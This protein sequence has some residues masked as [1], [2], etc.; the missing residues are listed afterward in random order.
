[1]KNSQKSSVRPAAGTLQAARR[2][3]SEDDSM[4][5]IWTAIGTAIWTTALTLGL[6]VVLLST[7]CFL[8]GSDDASLEKKANG[9]QEAMPTINGDGVLRGKRPTISWKLNGAAVWGFKLRVGTTDWL[10]RY[11]NSGNQP[12]STTSFA[13]Q[14]DLPEDGSEVIVSLDVALDQGWG[15]WVNADTRA[16]TS[17]G[18]DPPAPPPDDELL[19]FPGARG[20]GAMAS[21]GRGG[22]VYHVTSLDDGSNQGTLRYGI[23]EVA[24][25]GPLTIVFD[26]SGNIKLKR[27]LKI[28]SSNLTIA[29]QTAPDGGITLSGYPTFIE[30]ESRS[31]RIKDIIIRYVRFRTG[32]FNA[33][34]FGLKPAKGRGDL[35]GNGGDGVTILFAENIILD[36]VS[37]SW[38]MDETFDVGQSKLVTLQ[39]SMIYEGLFDSYH[40]NSSK[41]EI[42]KHSRTTLIR[43][44]N[45]PEEL[46]NKTRGYSFVGN[47]LAHSNM[48]MP[49]V[50]GHQHDLTRGTNIEFINN[51][52]YNWGERSGH[53]AT[54]A[55]LNMNYVANYL[56]AGPSTEQGTPSKGVNPRTAFRVEQETKDDLNKFLMYQTGNY[57]DSDLDATHDGTAV[58]WEAFIDFE[59]HEMLTEPHG[60]PTAE[61]R[62]A[63]DAYELVLVGSGASLSRDNDDSRVVSEIRNREGKIIDSQDE[64]GGLSVIDSVRRPSNFDTDNDGIPDD[65]EN[66]HGLDPTLSSDA[67]EIDSNT[68]GYTHLEVYLNSLVP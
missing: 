24:P 31:K 16:F 45:S 42:E 39:S 61:Y 21:G 50:G 18:G 26:V 51:V 46:D 64:I 53:T 60:F 67:R 65:W 27:R 3:K 1:M 11:G 40:T 44:M 56:I 15:T 34:A 58:D 63:P 32:D 68:V 36:H 12:V 30:G 17:D 55:M 62:S 66:D 13:M 10:D 19:A 48:R 6:L 57:I 23:E 38:G 47:V 9:A 28:E 20:F 54:N 5:L 41:T 52:I 25:Q 2:T 29:G 49:V 35:G 43:G 14:S 37:V 33:H 8:S 22:S 4:K 59:D 7:S